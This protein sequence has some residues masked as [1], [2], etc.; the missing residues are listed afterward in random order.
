MQRKVLV[1]VERRAPR[2]TILILADA[3]LRQL[4][5]L[6]FGNASPPAWMQSTIGPPDGSCTARALARPALRAHILS[7]KFCD[8][9]PFRRQECMA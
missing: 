6:R 1:G 5:E 7:D 9:R 8:S 2:K 3:D 4:V